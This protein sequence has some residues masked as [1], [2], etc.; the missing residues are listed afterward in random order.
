ILE[1]E[2]NGFMWEI[3][4]CEGQDIEGADYECPENARLV[5][6]SEMN[7][8]KVLQDN[9]RIIFQIPINQDT[10]ENVE[11]V[12]DE[13]GYR[14]GS[15]VTHDNARRD[16]AHVKLY[17]HKKSP[18]LDE[19][20]GVSYTKEGAETYL[21]IRMQNQDGALIQIRIN[22]G[23]YVDLVLDD[24]AVADDE[25]Y[26]TYR[27]QLEG[28][29]GNM[30][31]INYQLRFHNGARE[32]HWKDEEVID[33]TAPVITF[34][35][36]IIYVPYGGTWLMTDY[37]ALDDIDGDLTNSV[38]KIFLDADGLETVI[39][40]T[41]PG[42]YAIELSV[43][44]TAGN[45]AVE[46][47]SLIVG[48]DVPVA[49]NL[50]VAVAESLLAAFYDDALDN[51]LSVQ[52][53]CDKYI[54]DVPFDWIITEA[55]CLERLPMVRVV[56]TGYTMTTVKDETGDVFYTSTVIFNTLLGDVPFDVQYNFIG[57]EYGYISYLNFI[58]DPFAFQ[59]D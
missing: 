34:V 56:V 57:Y 9:D 41:T 11:Y 52:Q 7:I 25:G 48:S 14:N 40:T 43:A 6:V 35:D 54:A 46:V 33:L 1:V 32:Q 55:E 39:Y 21:N 58:T 10:D 30:K 53:V 2:V 27:I 12:V 15:I 59:L 51:S 38:M 23:E 22:G 16:I 49:F 17:T 47:I 42:S 44:D 28:H 4:M 26:Y 45:E 37:S 24:D 8:T 19:V 31:N 13:F 36:E 20:N 5:Q 18:M 29:M 50:D 3:G